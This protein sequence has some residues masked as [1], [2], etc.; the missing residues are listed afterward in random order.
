MID[1]KRHGY[2][3]LRDHKEK[4]EYKGNWENDLKHGDGR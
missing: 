3:I 4:T 1:G 2:G